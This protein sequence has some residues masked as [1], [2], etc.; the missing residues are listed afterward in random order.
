VNVTEQLLWSRVEG[1]GTRAQETGAKVPPFEL[2]KLTVPGGFTLFPAA[3][4]VSVTVAV[5]VT[6]LLTDTLAALQVTAVA[7]E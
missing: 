3:L 6:V 7:V 4:E 1:T 2:V 5:Q